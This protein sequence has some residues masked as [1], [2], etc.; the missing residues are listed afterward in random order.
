MKS[1]L[2]A[3]CGCDTWSGNPLCQRCAN[4]LETLG[5]GCPHGDADCIPGDRAWQCHECEVERQPI[6]S[7]QGN[8]KL[9]VYGSLLRGAGNGGMLG[10]NREPARLRGR[11]HYGDRTNSAFPVLVPDDSQWVLGEIVKGDIFSEPF[12]D[13][14]SMEIGVGYDL[15]HALAYP[16]E[17]LEEKEQ[18]LVFTWPWPEYGDPVPNNDW[19]RKRY[20]RGKMPWDE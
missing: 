18:V 10:K 13:V 11:L 3:N 19:L 15:R 2:C 1:A 16:L 17:F 9:F 14:I 12:R 4:D 20:P 6:S 7:T 5:K 8:D